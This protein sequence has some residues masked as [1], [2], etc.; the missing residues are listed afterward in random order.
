MIKLLNTNTSFLST[1]HSNGGNYG[2]VDGHVEKISK[3]VLVEAGINGFVPKYP[4][5]EE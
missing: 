1:A 4:W 3:M 2:L 5:R